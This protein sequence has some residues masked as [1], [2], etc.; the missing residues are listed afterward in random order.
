MPAPRLRPW[1]VGLVITA[2]L[3]LCV[4]ALIFGTIVAA[5]MIGNAQG[6]REWALGLGLLALAASPVVAARLGFRLRQDGP[7]ARGRALTGAAVMG[8]AALFWLFAVLRP[9]PLFGQDTAVAAGVPSALTLILVAGFI[10]LAAIS[11]GAS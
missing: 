4:P 10:A 8:P 1:V 5:A 9:S 2:A 7:G 3:L 11:T 6:A